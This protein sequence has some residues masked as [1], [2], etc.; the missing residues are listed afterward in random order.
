LAET[1][2]DS[3]GVIALPPVIFGAFLMAGLV[4]EYL[5]PWPVMAQTG[6]YI[7]GGIVIAASFV[8]MPGAVRGFRRAETHLDVRKPTSAIITDGPYRISRNPIYMSMLL[9]YLGIGIMI[10]GVWILLLAAPLVLV[11]Q[12]GVILREE[13]YLERKFGEAY[14]TYKQSVR[15]WI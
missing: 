14:L 5:F 6:Q 11:I 7:A 3:P 12:Y 2:N 8:L 4:P 15:R 1:E 9:L 10:D 13:A